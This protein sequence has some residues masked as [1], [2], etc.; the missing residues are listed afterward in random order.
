M[1]VRGHIIYVPMGP[2]IYLDSLTPP[3]AVKNASGIPTNQPAAGD[4]TL[5]DRCTLCGLV[6]TRRYGH[7][8]D[9]LSSLRTLTLKRAQTRGERRH[10]CVLVHLVVVVRKCPQGHVGGTC[11]SAAVVARIDVEQ[12]SKRRTATV[13][14]RSP[15]SGQSIWP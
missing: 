2:L 14:N 7:A 9:L 3:T 5:V 12:A 6:R 8:V 10:F 4:Q 1:C 13:G 15:P 11:D